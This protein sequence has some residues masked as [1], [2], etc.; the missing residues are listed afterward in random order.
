MKFL[1]TLLVGLLAAATARAATLESAE[2]TAAINA[3]SLVEGSQS[4]PATVGDILRGLA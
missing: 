2:V 3:V 1:T 4:R